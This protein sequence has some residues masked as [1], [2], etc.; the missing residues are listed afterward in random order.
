MGVLGPGESLGAG[1]GSELSQDAICD[2]TR[3]PPI[4]LPAFL[5][6]SSSS[7]E[8]EGGRLTKKG[9]DRLAVRRANKA[10]RMTLSWT[11][12]SSAPMAHTKASGGLGANFSAPLGGPRF[13]D[14]GPQEISEWGRLPVDATITI[15]PFSHPRGPEYVR[16]ILLSGNYSP[17]RE[18]RG[19]K[20]KTTKSRFAARRPEETERGTHACCQLV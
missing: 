19:R 5:F 18:V 16:Q 6:S 2:A 8:L 17:A 3:C 13:N 20:K 12:R 4:F 10:C 9:Q 7:P 14:D 15:K 1:G 11:S